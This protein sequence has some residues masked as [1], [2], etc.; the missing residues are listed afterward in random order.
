MSSSSAAVV[1][2]AAWV[3]KNE[4]GSPLEYAAYKKLV[5]GNVLPAEGVP[6]EREWALETLSPKISAFGGARKALWV[7]IL[8]IWRLAKVEGTGW[9]DDRW[10]NLLSAWLVRGD[11]LSCLDS[12]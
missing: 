6:E 3:P 5:V 11:L 4:S 9:A 1:F 8:A 12:D 10:C 2:E 7:C